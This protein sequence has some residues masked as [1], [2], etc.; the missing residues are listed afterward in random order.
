MLRAG[1]IT[2][3]SMVLK[4]TDSLSDYTLECVIE[5]DIPQPQTRINFY[6]AGT[7]WRP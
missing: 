5:H 2:W 3:I 1:I 4:D 7:P 6:C